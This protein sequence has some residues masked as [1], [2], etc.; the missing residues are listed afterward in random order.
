MPSVAKYVMLRAAAV[1]GLVRELHTVATEHGVELEVIPA[2]FHRPSSRAWLEGSF[3]GQLGQMVS[4]LLI[5]A[6]FESSAQVA[7]DLKW[8][9]WL[10]PNCQLSAG[11]NA[12]EPT[13][14][15]VTLAAQ[16]AACEEAQAQA[17]YIYNY[18]LLSETRL[19]WVGQAYAGVDRS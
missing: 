6:Y 18:G 9:R 4:G 7:A 8:A 17:I 10:A 1:T 16:V 14:D 15:S 12:C 5:P 13:L 3:L 2:S 11:L 19:N